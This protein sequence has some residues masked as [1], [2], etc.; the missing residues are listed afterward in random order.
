MSYIEL[1][2][3][4]IMMGF[5]RC[6]VERMDKLLE[7]ARKRGVLEYQE[8]YALRRRFK[9]AKKKRKE[10]ENRIEEVEQELAELKRSLSLEAINESR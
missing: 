2:D 9:E 7:A 5:T 3:A 10:I 4:K 8:D 1:R 6:E